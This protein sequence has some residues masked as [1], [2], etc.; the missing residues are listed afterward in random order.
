MKVSLKKIDLEWLCWMVTKFGA[1]NPLLQAVN[2]PEEATSDHLYRFLCVLNTFNR[3]GE[4][5]VVT[6]LL[7]IPNLAQ[8]IQNHLPSLFAMKIIEEKEDNF[9]DVLTLF[10][11]TKLNLA[12]LFNKLSDRSESEK[13]KFHRIFPDFKLEKLYTSGS[14]SPLA[15]SVAQ[16]KENDNLQLL[17]VT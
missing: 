16:D 1:A 12:M 11:A 9:F 15:K 5:E 10:D 4:T 14:T 7:D 3:A 8:A 2:M 6:S 17:N 13:V